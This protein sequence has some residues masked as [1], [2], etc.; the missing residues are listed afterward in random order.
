MGRGK[1][2]TMKGAL[3]GG[4]SLLELMFAL[5]VFQVGVLGTAGL[6]LMAQR[7]LMRAELTVR[8][9]L[10]A[11]L[12]ADSV[13]DA[14]AGGSGSAE[15]PWGEVSWSPAPG[16]PGGVRAVAFANH[17]GDTVAVVTVWPS[18][19]MESTSDAGAASGSG[20]DGSGPG[21]PGAGTGGGSP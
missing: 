8:G 13:M 21:D 16:V 5:V 11:R 19:G 4:F 17:V 20:P 15:H 14:G 7:N 12:V 10:E 3:E 2:G 6:V 18:P 9:V 1:G